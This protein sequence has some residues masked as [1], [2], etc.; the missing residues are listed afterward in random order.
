MTNGKNDSQPKQP[1]KIGRINS[2]KNKAE[3]T[4]P[5]G[6]MAKMTR[7]PLHSNLCNNKVKWHNAFSAK[8]CNKQESYDAQ[9]RLV[10]IL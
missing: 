6:L 8:Q 1:T 7:I 2:P 9:C 3:T 10:S 4:R 5:Q